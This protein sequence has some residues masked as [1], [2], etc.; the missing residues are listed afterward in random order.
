MPGLAGMHAH[1]IVEGDLLPLLANGVTTILNMGEVSAPVLFWRNQIQLGERI[2]PTVYAGAWTRSGDATG[3]E[4]Q[5]VRTPGR[6]RSYIRQKKNQGYDFIKV[7]SVGA[8]GFSPEVFAAIME[9]AAN[10]GYAVMGH[11]RGTFIS[12]RRA[13]EL[14]QVMVAHAEEYFWS[15]FNA[16]HNT[17]LIQ[18]AIDFTL[19]SGA[20]VT[21]S[22]MIDKT[23]SLIQGNV[24][25][26]L[27]QLLAQ[28]GN[29]FLDPNGEQRWRNQ[30]N[31]SNL[32]P[33]GSQ[34]DQYVPTYNFIKS[35]TKAFSDAGVPLL[36]GSDMGYVG[37]IPGFT[38]H[39]EMQIL[40]EIGL[41]PYQILET[42]TKNASE[43]I[44][45]YIPGASAFGIIE[46]GRQADLILLDA[47]PLE[48]IAN[49][50]NRVGVMTRGHWFS[51]T[52]LEQMLEELAQSY[53]N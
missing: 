10:Q 24:E 15:H 43:F 25:G 14:G 53:G 13:L 50:K 4:G 3:P 31:T 23:I 41:T 8:N 16:T 39:E 49:V 26:G 44:T 18:D 35:Y 20:Y 27:A 30:I 33:P 40:S 17:S 12:T 1:L 2:G 7:W 9:E 29:R 48:D 6:A 5:K 47:N 46:P 45:Q 52:K 37:S 42:G 28:P 11:A 32:S 38:I 22:L 34:P 51:E 19:N 21:P 36:L